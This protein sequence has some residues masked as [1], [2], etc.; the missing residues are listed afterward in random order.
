MALNAHRSQYLTTN[1]SVYAT[2]SSR[3]FSAL[4]TSIV[5][6]VLLF[7][8]VLVTVGSSIVALAD[9][10]DDAKNKINELA[11]DFIV[12][13]ADGE[14]D[15][16]ATL[17]KADGDTSTDSFGYILNR[18]FATNYIN[19]APK[20][21][22]DKP[23][24]GVNCTVGNKYSGTPLY[25]NCDVPN[26]FTEFMQ[27]ALSVLTQSGPTGAN[28][29]SAKLDVPQ[30]GLPT[31]IPG[32]GAPVKASERAVKY[33]ALELFGYNLKFTSYNGE[34]DH[35]KVMTAARTMS[36]FGFMDNLKLGVTAV[37]NG[38]AS[39]VGQGVTNFL[40]GLSSG[41]IFGA[42]GG[43]FSGFFKKGTG[44]IV[45]TV[46]DTSDQNV[47]NT[48][49]WYRVGY[50]G[51]LYNAREKT[52]EEIAANAKSQLVKTIGQSAPSEA[53]TPADL[54]SI[55]GGLPDPLEAISKCMFKNASGEMEEYG[56]TDIA[57]GPTEDK[58]KE[59]SKKAAEA[60]NSENSEDSESESFEAKHEWSIDGNQKLET[61]EDWK[62]NNE[63]ALAIAASYE[64]VITIDI[65]EA[66]RANTIA[67]IKAVW[68]EK[69]K[70]AQTAIVNEQQ[71]GNNTEWM[72]E[73]LSPNVFGMWVQNT[74]DANYNAPWNRFICTDKHGKDILD[75]AGNAVL[76]YN[77]EGVLNEACQPV[78]APIQNGF[79]GNGYVGEIPNH[80]T[81][82]GA[83]DTSI[84][85]TLIPINSI[86]TATSNMGLWTAVTVT[87][88]SNTV[89][90]LSFSPLLES[91]G[92]DEM[93]LS[94]IN[95]LRDGV[96]F[97]FLVF[98]VGIA[99]VMALW[100]AGKNQDYGK[101][102]IS[103]LF[104]TLTIMSGVI[105]MYIPDTMI[106]A[107]DEVP[108]MIE[109]AIVGTIFSV[110]NNP[111]DKLCTATGTATAVKDKDL[112][113]KDV[114]FSASEGTRSLLCENWRTFAFNPW[115]YGQFGTNMDQLYAAGT[116]AKYSLKNTNGGLVG[117]AGV[118]MGAGQTVNNW[119]LYQLDTVT[120]GTASFVDPSAKDGGVSRDFYRIV[121]VMAGPT[122]TATKVDDRF[123]AA[124]SGD[125]P[126]ARMGVGLIAP[127]VSIVGA[128]TVVVYSF[129]KIQASFVVT[130]L[131][132]IMPIMF[133]LG[134]HPSMGRTKLKGYFG[135]IVSLIMQRIVLVLV[136]AVMFR[137]LASVGTVTTDYLLMALVTVMICIAFLSFRKPIL[138]MLF[139]G[140]SSTFG[141]PVGE[142]FIRNP[143]DFAASHGARTP[144][145][146]TNWAAMQ[147]SGIQGA[148]A[149]VMAGF[150][151]GGVSGARKGYAE[152]RDINK[153]LVA[154]SQ[155]RMGYGPLQTGWEAMKEGKNSALR[156][157]DD[158]VYVSKI[159][160]DVQAQTASQSNYDEAMTLWNKLP[161]EKTENGETVGV[162]PVTGE[163]VNK[164]IP[165]LAFADTKTSARTNRQLRKMADMQRKLEGQVLRREEVYIEKAS[166][167]EILGN[168]DKGFDEYTSDAKR[169]E[170]EYEERL[171]KQEKRQE[172]VNDA[173]KE[174]EVARKKEKLAD[175]IKPTRQTKRSDKELKAALDD[176]RNRAENHSK[177]REGQHL[178]S[179]LPEDDSAA[180]SD[181][182]EFDEYE[183][184]PFGVQDEDPY[185]GYDDGPE[186]DS[187]SD[188]YFDRNIQDERG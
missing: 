51:T 45:N 41:N 85:G 122:G 118:S 93:V 186:P 40:S 18:L 184:I 9:S 96:F 180:Y 152:S 46:L 17:V 126:A 57:P 75:S 69:W 104:M 97:P 106:K 148:T 172:Y 187:T 110:G 6:A 109:R 70:A 15:L 164:P 188:P 159:R 145:A 88:L 150:I 95:T 134:V 43:F 49:A 182:T 112:E 181:R 115:V 64:M 14:A 56:K 105:L 79:F 2:R 1:D 4:F 138:D 161:K 146:V 72:N 136:L 130:L 52:A 66:N 86:I 103:L 117:N 5:A 108:S 175:S 44:A 39:G 22:A 131:L 74:P 24:G 167:R 179:L 20:S 141:A 13:G 62:K 154:N 87:R 100:S 37:L 82:Y 28:A 33:T 120:S 162:D 89:I 113:G 54:A 119:A 101:Q 73:Q 176:L 32:D 78:R 50:G 58:C 67:A 35:I 59:Q 3:A 55:K 61:M 29:N 173:E 80:D 170:S 139:S 42:I 31:D 171:I 127:I 27:D 25:H 16:A 153:G 8:I 183:D 21:S 143:K 160:D 91:F 165:P 26:I 68:D 65:N 19:L 129:A 177:F 144:S 30:F 48:H 121:D 163:V 125:D 137:V 77:H 169:Y 53:E 23:E 83:M 142:Q 168:E 34:W 124:W 94:A 149:G 47:F 147:K 178:E 156:E 166:E 90:S 7:A 38:V 92:I 76:L 71:E 123:F 157:L 98:V 158:D 114:S 128:V 10:T 60:A 151:T 140:M 107:V 84:I 12:K 36:N 63:A 155:R 116:G 81:R 111:E 135:S 11:N 185:T 132:L 174:S 133:L 102:A 99:G